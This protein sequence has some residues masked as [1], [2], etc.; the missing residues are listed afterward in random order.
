M[1]AWRRL[2]PPSGQ[3]DFTPHDGAGFACGPARRRTQLH[4]SSHRRTDHAAFAMGSTA[5]EVSHAYNHIHADRHSFGNRRLLELVPASR[6]DRSSRSCS[7]VHPARSRSA[8]ANCRTRSLE[9]QVSLFIGSRDIGHGEAT[10]TQAQLA[11]SESAREEINRPD[12]MSIRTRNRSGKARDAC[13]RDDVF[14]SI[15]HSVGSLFIMSDDQYTKFL[16]QGAASA[17]RP[18]KGIARRCWHRRKQTS[19]GFSHLAR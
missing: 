9:A 4:A 2:W 6:P 5:W 19:H 1:P 3:A 17:R 7:E 18:C 16:S 10:V 12:A 14:R 13:G 11:D 8:G 15:V